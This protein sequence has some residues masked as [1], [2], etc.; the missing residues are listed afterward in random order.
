MLVATPDSQSVFGGPLHQPTAHAETATPLSSGTVEEVKPNKIMSGLFE[1]IGGT[2]GASRLTS[3]DFRQP[4]K[5]FGAKAT[6]S[7]LPTAQ[8]T[9]TATSTGKFLFF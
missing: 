5:K 6:T 3:G 4:Q 9:T 1:G 7:T 2:G 8:R